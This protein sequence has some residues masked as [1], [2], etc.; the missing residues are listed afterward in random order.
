MD[1]IAFTR[2][3]VDIDST[4]GREAEA[5]RWLSRQLRE[6]GFTVVEQEVDATRFNILALAGPP[7]VVFSTHVDCVPPFVPARIEG[8]RLYGRGACDA[9]GILAAQVAAADRLRR[10]G[11]TRVGL[12]FVVGEERGS[13][14]A[15]AANDAADQGVSEAARGCRYLVDGEPTDS[16]LG[17]AT[18]GMLRVKL[19]A[20]GRAAHS[21]F[22]ELGASA[23][24]T[25]IDALIEL[26]AIDLPSDP[27]LGRTHYTVGL[28]AG[29][30]AP[31]VVSPSAEAEVMF[32]TVADGATIRQ[33]LELIERRVRIEHVLEVPPVRL[34]TV[35][36][37]DTAVFPFTTDIPLLDRW[38]TPL[39][40]GPGSIHVAHTAEEYVS[41]AELHAAVDHYITIAR[42]LL[43]TM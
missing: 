15:K 7:T 8:D 2:A 25:L 31:N 4:T 13:D 21:A 32:R 18:R 33:A 6:A 20:S 37:F 23:I 17:L 30:V 29:G 1:P 19:H 38:G 43:N 3:L 40:F 42:H 24:D 26:R 5:G 11:E 27:I 39:L 22:P 41:I 10:E 16:R 36:G 28:I 9:K 12:L 14:G 34:T 35:P